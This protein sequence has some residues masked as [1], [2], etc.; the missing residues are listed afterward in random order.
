MRVYL[1]DYLIGCLV[2]LKLCNELAVLCIL[3]KNERQDG[4]LLVRLMC[5]FTGK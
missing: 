3:I 4:V 2:V 5:H 1:F